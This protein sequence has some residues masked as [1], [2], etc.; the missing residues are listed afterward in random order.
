MDSIEIDEIMPVVNSMHKILFKPETLSSND[1][2]DLE[3]LLALLEQ[4]IRNAQ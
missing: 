3:N 2:R 1:R 4:K